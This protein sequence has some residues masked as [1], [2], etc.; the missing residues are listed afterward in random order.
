MVKET[1]YA[2][3]L[4]LITT[5]CFCVKDGRVLACNPGARALLL[6]IGTPIAPLLATGQEAYAQYQG[7]SLFL[8]LELEGIR[9]GATVERKGDVDFFLL[10]DPQEEQE[11]R[12]LS[13]AARDLRTPLSGLLA[14]AESLRG[15][16]ADSPD[17]QRQLGLMNRNLAQMLRVIGNMSAAGSRSPHKEFLEITAFFRE[18]LQKAAAFLS[19]SGLAL[20]YEEPETAIYTLADPQELERAALNLLSNAAKFSPKGGLIQVSLKR[21]GR[22]LHLTVEDQGSGIPEENRGTLFQRYLRGPSIE[23]IRQGI[24]LGM[25]LVR[26]AA[27]HHGGTVLVD[28]PP[29]G[30]TRVCMTFAI[31]QDIPDGFRS[32]LLKVDYAGERDH[33]LIELA[34]VLPAECYLDF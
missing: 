2:Q 27:A 30:G 1:P 8:T 18:I 6:P 3:M 15:F 29:Q 4:D 9:F 32:T 20:R 5:P 13:L 10:E 11:L 25:V 12:A 22:M 26:T 33:A 7:G 31:C 34:D 17:A 24:G 28:F 23:D 21:Q 19:Q 16:A 14:T